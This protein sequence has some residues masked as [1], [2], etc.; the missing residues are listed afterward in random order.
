MVHNTGDLGKSKVSK[1]MGIDIS[2]LD[3]QAHTDRINLEEQFIKEQERLAKMK[4]QDN[5]FD[6][7]IWDQY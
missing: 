4:V 6:D 1:A 3:D 7:E 2:E 5:T